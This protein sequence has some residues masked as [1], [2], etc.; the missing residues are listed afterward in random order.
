MQNGRPL[1]AG[2]FPLLG[3][4]HVLIGRIRQSVAHGTGLR[5]QCTYIFVNMHDSRC[6]PCTASFSHAQQ[7]RSTYTHHLIDTRLIFNC[8]MERIAG[9][10]GVTKKKK[11]EAL[12]IHAE[13]PNMEM[14]PE[15]M[16]KI[17]AH[18][19]ACQILTGPLMQMYEGIFSQ[20]RRRSSDVAADS[21]ILPFRTR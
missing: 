16:P 21:K 1:L 19:F 10:S 20:R 7:P 12:T 3:H 15:G 2:Q 5:M 17:A 13:R 6:P 8:L 4:R 9:T 14:T 11:K 18:L